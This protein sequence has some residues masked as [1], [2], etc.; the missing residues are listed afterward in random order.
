MT[1]KN[2]LET[3]TELATA[4]GWTV[5]E[6]AGKFCDTSRSFTHED[7]TMVY[8]GFDNNKIAGGNGGFIHYAEGGGGPLSMN[9]TAFKEFFKPESEKGV[10]PKVELTDSKEI[11]VGTGITFSL[12]S[13]S[14][15]Y[16]IVKVI[17]EKKIVVRRCTV[18]KTGEW[19]PKFHAGG[20]VAHC[21]NQYDQHKNYTY[22]DNEENGTAVLTL[23]KNEWWVKQGDSIGR[24]DSWRIGT[25][26]EFYDY[27]F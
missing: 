8:I 26:S 10:I 3:L 2:Q 13:D 24:K 7:G 9:F 16:T 1:R 11:A 4:N 19:K 15:A 14:H 5:K 12:Y 27:N 6:E 18:H 17:N 21:S 23:R 22:E 20:F 25:R